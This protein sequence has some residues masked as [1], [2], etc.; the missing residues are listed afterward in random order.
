MAINAI[1]CSSMKVSLSTLF[2]N[3]GFYI[4][5]NVESALQ[6]VLALN[7]LLSGFTTAEFTNHRFSN[8]NP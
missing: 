8:E 5:N 4:L 2:A 7:L 1:K 3:F 6:P